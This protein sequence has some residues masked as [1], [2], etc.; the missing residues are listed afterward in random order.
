[1]QRHTYLY[2]TLFFILIS[3]GIDAQVYTLSGKVFDSE[4]KEPLPFVPVMLKGTT[5]GATTDF[6]GNYSITT[7]KLSDSLIC[8]YVGFKRMTR[9][10]KRGQ[11]QLVNF[12]LVAEGY[13]LGEVVI[14]PGENPAHRIIRNVIANKQYN[15]KRKLEAYQYESYNKVEFDLSRIPKEMREDRKSVV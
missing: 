7:S 9:P 4:T 5:I 6:D 8:S 10:I 12:P 11:T 14:N 2:F 3:L 15:N 13:N 1:M